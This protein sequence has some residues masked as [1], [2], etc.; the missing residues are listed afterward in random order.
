M[1]KHPT[2]EAEKRKVFSTGKKEKIQSFEEIHWLRFSW[3]LLSKGPRKT[4]LGPTRYP[5]IN[6][7]NTHTQLPWDA[8]SWGAEILMFVYGIYMYFIDKYFF[9]WLAMKQ[10]WWDLEIWVCVFVWCDGWFGGVEGW[11]LEGLVCKRTAWFWVGWS[12]NPGWSWEKSWR[13]ITIFLLNRRV[14]EVR[15]AHLLEHIWARVWE[16]WSIMR[17]LEL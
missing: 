12:L 14:R 16:P 17:I 1:K 2:C 4:D 10:K 6:S 15:E 11:C 7:S 3:T 9:L 8:A 13:N 5:S